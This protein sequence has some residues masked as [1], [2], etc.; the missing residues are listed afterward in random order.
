MP[1]MPEGKPAGMRC[2]NLDDHNLCRLFGRPER[3]AFCRGWQPDP[4]VCGGS[5][6]EAMA[7]I[8]GLEKATSGHSPDQE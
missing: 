4:A 3:P 6:E 7:N 8:A 1:G 2:V 5:F